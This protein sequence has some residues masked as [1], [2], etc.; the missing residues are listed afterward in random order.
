MGDALTG[1]KIYDNVVSVNYASKDVRREDLSLSLVETP[2]NYRTP[3]H[4]YGVSVGLKFSIN[5]PALRSPVPSYTL[6]PSSN[7]P[8]MSSIIISPV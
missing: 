7:Q 1:E 8:Y 3:A 6:Q 2:L 5:K 4:I